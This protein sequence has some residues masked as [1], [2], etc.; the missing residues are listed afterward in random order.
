MIVIQ[1]YDILLTLS[2]ELDCIWRRKITA[3]TVI[4]AVI[5]YGTLLQVSVQIVLNTWTPISASVC[6]NFWFLIPF[7]YASRGRSFRTA[8]SCIRRSW[9]FDC[10]TS[11]CIAVIHLGYVMD[12]LELVASAGTFPT[13]ATEGP[14]THSLQSSPF[15]VSG[16][17]HSLDYVCPFLS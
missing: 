17:S 8:C 5:R 1:V 15:F 7:W 3:V 14:L 4:Y 2:R 11:N 10:S 9:Y 16:Q 12:V 6:Y 13:C